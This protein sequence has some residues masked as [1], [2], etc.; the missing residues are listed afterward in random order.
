MDDTEIL[1]A[2]FAG[3]VIK[4]GS[5]KLSFMSS[6]ALGMLP[7][8]FI[9]LRNGLKSKQTFFSSEHDYSIIL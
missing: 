1:S 9:S 8:D 7:D 5:G 3:P 2:A 6:A 4:E